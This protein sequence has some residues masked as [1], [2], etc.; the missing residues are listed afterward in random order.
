[1][2]YNPASLRGVIDALEG[3]WAVISLDDGQ[4]L[5]WPRERLPGDAGVGMVIV[6]SL[7]PT[8]PS[9][10]QSLAGTWTGIA[11]VQSQE[12]SASPRI[13]LGTQQLKWPASLE[14]PAGDKVVLRIQTDTQDTELRR[15]QVQN[16]VDDLFG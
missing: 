9:A 14:C 3:D 11:R 1:M 16:L 5:N 8:G 12:P 6:L 15:N 13:E 7:E 2:E 4:R 10:Q